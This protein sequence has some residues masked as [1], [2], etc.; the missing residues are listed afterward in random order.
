MNNIV[1]G[2]ARVLVMSWNPDLG[3]WQAIARR[4]EKR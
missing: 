2:G 1:W 3:T 4:E